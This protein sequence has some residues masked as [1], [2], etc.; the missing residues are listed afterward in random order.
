MAWHVRFSGLDITGPFWPAGSG[1]QRGSAI[2]SQ[3][4]GTVACAP[5]QAQH[6][7]ACLNHDEKGA[8]GVMC[9]C[10]SLAALASPRAATQMLHHKSGT[11]TCH[12]GTLRQSHDQ[13]GSLRYFIVITNAEH[14]PQSTKFPCLFCSTQ[15][16]GK[17]VRRGAILAVHLPVPHS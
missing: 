6:L 15:L 13:L 9:G 14:R 17:C 2:E 12:D 4:E 5:Q 10:G 3:R 7:R 1:N 16:I 8:V 11:L